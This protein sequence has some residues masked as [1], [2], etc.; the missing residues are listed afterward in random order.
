MAKDHLRS[1]M[2]QVPGVKVAETSSLGASAG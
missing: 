2:Q 1:L